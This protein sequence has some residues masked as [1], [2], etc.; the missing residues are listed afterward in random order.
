MG[1]SS[2]NLNV[3]VWIDEAAHEQPVYFRVME[4]CKLA[5]DSA[6]IEIPYPHLQLFIENVEDRVWEKAGAFARG[7]SGGR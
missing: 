2:I 5:L 1:A 3:R 4:A 7:S 6:G